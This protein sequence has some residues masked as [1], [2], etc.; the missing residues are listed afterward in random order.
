MNDRIYRR[1]LAL[2]SELVNEDPERDTPD[3]QLLDAVSS[4][5]EQHERSYYQFVEP[6][7]ADLAAFRRAV[8]RGE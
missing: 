8:M 4:A 3:G 6:S 2:V 7:P 5:I 1:A